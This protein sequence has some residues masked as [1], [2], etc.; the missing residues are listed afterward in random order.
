MATITDILAEAFNRVKTEHGVTLSR[1]EFEHYSDNLAGVEFTSTGSVRVV[2]A[3]MPPQLQTVAAPPPALDTISGPPKNATH[4]GGVQGGKIAFWRYEDET[5]YFYSLGSWIKLE[6]LT[7]APHN[8][9]VDE[10]TPL[11]GSPPYQP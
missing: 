11:E 6:A 10:L 9:L 2:V 3:P 8:H 1:V 7:D 5:L 4:V